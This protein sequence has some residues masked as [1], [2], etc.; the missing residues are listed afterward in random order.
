MCI[1]LTEEDLFKK[2]AKKVPFFCP[3]SNLPQKCCPAA[4][5][6]T[7]KNDS[8]YHI[9][10]YNSN[11]RPGFRVHK[12]IWGSSTLSSTLIVRECEV[13]MYLFQARMNSFQTGMNS[14]Q[15]GMNSFQGGK[16]KP[17]I[18]WTFWIFSFAQNSRTHVGGGM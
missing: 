16:S 11:T 8:K 5:Q 7:F 10:P 3:F 9:C 14:F 13:G 6:G 2:H 1:I 17:L 18:E 4:V 15:L 12:K